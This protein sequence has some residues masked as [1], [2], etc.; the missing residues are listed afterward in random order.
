MSAIK[1]TYETQKK[2]ISSHTTLKK[3]SDT[4][5]SQFPATSFEPRRELIGIMSLGFALHNTLWKGELLWNWGGVK[6][7][8]LKWPISGRQSPSIAI[9]FF[10][11]WSFRQLQGVLPVVKTF[12]LPA[13][14]WS[15]PFIVV[16]T[17]SII[18]YSDLKNQSIGPGIICHLAGI[19]T[20][21]LLH[22][23]DYLQY[24]LVIP[25]N[26]LISRSRSRFRARDIINI[27]FLYND[28]KLRC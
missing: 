3:D 2:P 11:H 28:Q 7:S 22:F 1:S 4:I 8:S 17:F 19:A 18:Q 25:C 9:S 5:F 26:F 10:I 23:H 13:M 12:V 16:S 21:A 20:K 15:R 27:V 24:Y 6:G 14:P